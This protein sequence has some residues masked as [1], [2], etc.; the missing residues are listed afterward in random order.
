[1]MPRR[2]FVDSGA[3]FAAQVVDDAHHEEAAS[4]LRGLIALPIVLVTTNHVVGE[5]YTLLRVTRG[6]NACRRFLESLDETRRLERIFV[7]QDLERR[8]FA[9]LDRYH[10]HEF[11]FVD[12]TSFAFMRTERIRHAFA[13]ASHFA[14][15]GF[16]RVPADVAIGQLGD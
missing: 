11:S 9:I 8:A 13:F 12:A 2:V 5:T 4:D 16:V 1:M 15:A 14:A 3:W 6:Y 7:S 10:D